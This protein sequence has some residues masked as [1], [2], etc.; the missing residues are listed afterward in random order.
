M[1]QRLITE[2][3]M[4]HLQKDIIHTILN[5]TL[6]RTLVEHS[7][8]NISNTFSLDD[9]RNRDLAYYYVKQVAKI[10]LLRLIIAKMFRRMK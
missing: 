1:K 9:K 3:K 6:S 10:L 5:K 4:C 2:T 8:C 7:F